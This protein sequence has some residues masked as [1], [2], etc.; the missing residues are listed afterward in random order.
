MKEIK[1]DIRTD[2]EDSIMFQIW[3]DFQVNVL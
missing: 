1:P 3:L 2:K